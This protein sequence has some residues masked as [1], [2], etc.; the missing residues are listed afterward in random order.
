MSKAKDTR[1]RILEAARGLLESA[2]GAPVAMS[3]IA[4]AAG[5]T[6]QLLYFHF[7]NRTA[8]LLE[9]TRLVDAEAR[10]PELQATIDNAADGCQALRAAVRVQAAIKPKIHGVASSL[11]VLRPTDD[12]AAAACEEREEARLGRCRAVI[13]RL[14]REGLL[15][16]GW[17]R[18]T[19][20]ELFWSMTSLR[21]WDDLIHR[22][23]WTDQDWIRW[24][25]AT[26]EAALVADE[27]RGSVGGTARVVRASPG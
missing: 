5:V 6:R 15:A 4:A 14:A 21:A 25:T 27:G 20:A 10:T 18:E 1:R 23:A 16:P 26:L 9:L 12:A 22:R 17:R 11:E 7:E 19:A 24:T 13:D 2:P 8:L 3:D